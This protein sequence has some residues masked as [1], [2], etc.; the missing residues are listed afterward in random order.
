M[1]KTIAKLLRSWA[2][3]LDPMEPREI[4]H[5]EQRPD[6]VI[7]LD[8]VAQHMTRLKLD[9]RVSGAML[10]SEALDWS[11]ER[12][13]KYIKRECAAQM[14]HKLQDLLHLSFRHGDAVV[15]GSVFVYNENI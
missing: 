4:P 11:H 2:Q 6:K 12:I 5:T 14:A 8:Y 3:K 9:V 7:A 10:P 1:K 15:R 13:E